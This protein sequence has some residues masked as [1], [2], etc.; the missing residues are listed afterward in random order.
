MTNFHIRLRTPS[1]VAWRYDDEAIPPWV[2]R[3]T[4]MCKDNLVLVRGADKQVIHFGEWLVL[5]HD[6]EILHIGDATVRGQYA[7]VEEIAHEQR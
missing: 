3:T 2:A 1:L 4:V 5:D 6:N 7:V